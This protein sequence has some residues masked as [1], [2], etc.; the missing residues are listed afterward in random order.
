MFEIILYISLA[1]ISISN[2]A[3]IYRVIKGPTHPDRAIALDMIGIN[4]IASAGILTILVDAY[5]FT[6]VILLIG[7]LSFIGTISIAKYIERGV[8]IERHRNK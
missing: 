5:A 6:E 1:F 8:V 7:I 3:G 4:I 2:I